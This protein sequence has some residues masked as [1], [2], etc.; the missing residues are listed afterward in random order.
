MTEIWNEDYL[1]IQADR[2]VALGLARFGITLEQHLRHPER[3]VDLR[4]DFEPLLPAQRAVRDR[5]DASRRPRSGRTELVEREAEASVAELPLREVDG[6]PI[7]KLRHH[8]HAN[9]RARRR[10]HRQEVSNG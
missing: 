5:L 1:E 8:R 9:Y 10:A 3:Y 2:F 6:A 7:E 4:S